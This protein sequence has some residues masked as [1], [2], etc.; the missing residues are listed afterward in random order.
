MQS[1]PQHP[2]LLAI[3]CRD[4]S[5]A[6]LHAKKQVKHSSSPKAV[7]HTRPVWAVAWRSEQQGSPPA[8]HSLSSDGRLLLWTLAAAELRCEVSIL[9]LSALP[10]IAALPSLSELR[11]TVSCMYGFSS[12][13]RK[14]KISLELA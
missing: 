9:S 13:V 14:N 7:H 4:G 2:Y 11:H 3:G 5:C 12:A 10:I 1:H 6:I 8:F